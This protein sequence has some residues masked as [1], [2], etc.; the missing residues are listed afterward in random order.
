MSK[1]EN[2]NFYIVEDGHIEYASRWDHHIAYNKNNK[3]PYVGI[4]FK[5][6]DFSYFSPMFSPKKQHEGYKENLTF[7]KMY[8]NANKR[9]YLGLIRFADM[10]PVPEKAIKQLDFRDYRNLYSMLLVKQYNY[11]NI[12]ENKKRIKE[13]A[14]KLYNIINSDKENKTTYFYK[15]LCCNFKLLEGKLTR[16]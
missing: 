12:P 1:I 5:I 9:D 11:I 2:L 6:N 10:I 8:G 3:R 13:K 16:Y 15:K 7:F 14:K 4:V